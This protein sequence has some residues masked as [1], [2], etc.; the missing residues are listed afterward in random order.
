[1]LCRSKNPWRFRHWQKNHNFCIRKALMEVQSELATS[2]NELLFAHL[3]LLLWQS[4]ACICRLQILFLKPKTSFGGL[5][6]PFWRLT[7]H[8]RLSLSDM[9]FPLGPLCL[10]WEIRTGEAGLCQMVSVSVDEGL[11]CKHCKNAFFIAAE[12]HTRS[13]ELQTLYP[14]CVSGRV[15]VVP[16]PRKTVFVLP[17]QYTWKVSTSTH[18]FALCFSVLPDLPLKPSQVSE[19]L[20]LHTWS[21]S[22]FLLA[23]MAIPLSLKEA[24]S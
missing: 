12:E 10:L 17:F 19:L 5:L 14:G 23:T 20:F 6:V 9:W 3:H 22:S 13:P 16:G 1:M 2:R 11:S 15:E 21:L 18:I 7:I 24:I 8:V 4:L